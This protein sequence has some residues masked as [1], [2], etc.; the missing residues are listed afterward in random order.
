MT[1]VAILTARY[2]LTASSLAGSIAWW[3]EDAVIEDSAAAI[4]TLI[5][6]FTV[7]RAVPRM[8]WP[9]SLTEQSI[10]KVR[11]ASACARSRDETLREPCSPEPA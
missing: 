9:L 11:L 2:A 4:L 10:S 7:S 3:E 5:S 1:K 8:N 6:Q